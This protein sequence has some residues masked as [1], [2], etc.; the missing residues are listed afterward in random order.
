MKQVKTLAK[1]AKQ[2]DKEALLQF[3]LA[4]KKEYYQLTY[5]YVENEH[6]A[7]DTLNNGCNFI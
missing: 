1:K 7:M 5:T 3:G 2:G 6:N 4:D